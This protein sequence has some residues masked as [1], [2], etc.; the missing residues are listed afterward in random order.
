MSNE[1]N[2]TRPLRVV[3]FNFLPIG[4]RLLTEWIHK[5]G[6]HHVLAVT[7]P[8]PKSRPTP[9]Y[10]ELIAMAPRDLEVLVTTRLTKVAAPL[11]REL[12]PDLITCLSFPYRITP[13]LCEIPTY[14]AVNLHPAVLPAY[15]GPNVMRQFYEAAP[16]FGATAHWIAEDYDTGNILSQKAAPMPEVIDEQVLGQWVGMMSAAIAEGMERAVAGDKGQVQDNAKASYAAPFSEEERFLNWQ[17]PFAVLKRKT[18]ALNMGDASYARAKIGG[19][20]LRVLGLELLSSEQTYPLG[21]CI[22]RSDESIDIQTV[23][24]IVRLKVKPEP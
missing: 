16:L 24:G 9:A 20:T 22:E 8:G 6:H 2:I 4:F 3:T 13:E 17:D 1:K 18:L 12:K 11:I 10:K 19:E 14:G 23:G 5:M 7:T 15:R 21:S